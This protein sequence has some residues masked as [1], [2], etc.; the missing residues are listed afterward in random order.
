M[1]RW[2]AR[3]ERKLPGIA[4][5]R[6]RG[7]ER[8]TATTKTGP[9]SGKDGGG[10]PRRGSRDLA[11]PGGG[12]VS[13][14]CNKSSWQGQS[15]GR[16]PVGRL[17][18]AR[19]CRSVILPLAL[20]SAIRP[21]HAKTRTTDYDVPTPFSR[22]GVEGLG[23]VDLGVPELVVEG[24]QHVGARDLHAGRRNGPVG[25]CRINGL[26]ALDGGDVERLSPR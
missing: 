22:S 15:S 6:G 24:E 4:A 19:P 17:F 3:V 9:F 7:G 14:F 1:K 11:N 10:R 5:I 2:Q 8:T 16:V 12:L 23:K 13:S 26:L 25:N 18:S 21:R 20:G